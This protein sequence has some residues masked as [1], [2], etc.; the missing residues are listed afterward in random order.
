MN[1]TI[2]QSG[3]IVF[4]I[5]ILDTSRRIIGGPRLNQLRHKRRSWAFDTDI[6]CNRTQ[7][8]HANVTRENLDWQQGS[9]FRAVVRFLGFGLDAGS[10]RRL[11][12][13]RIGLR[14]IAFRCNRDD[15]ILLAIRRA[16]FATAAF[17]ILDGGIDVARATFAIFTLATRR[18]R[19]TRIIVIEFVTLDDSAIDTD[20]RMPEQVHHDT[21]CRRKGDETQRNNPTLNA[22]TATTFLFNG[23]VHRIPNLSSLVSSKS[24]W[25]SVNP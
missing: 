21:E 14:G 19:S 7:D 25:E 4:F 15:H 1:A 11:S 12:W 10:G 23:T 17:L 18:G 24:F 2:T 22:R 5:T 6:S 8:T 13:V 16:I 3:L 9:A 20:G